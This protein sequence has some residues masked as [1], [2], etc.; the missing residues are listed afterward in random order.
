MEGSDDVASTAP[1]TMTETS[2]GHWNDDYNNVFVDRR[3]GYFVVSIRA[4]GNRSVQMSKHRS[5]DIAIK[6]AT[7]IANGDRAIFSDHSYDGPAK[8]AR[9]S[10]APCTELDGDLLCKMHADQWVRGERREELAA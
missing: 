10:Q 3:R 1:K 6:A 8:C 7:K 9:C 4:A 2:P 5:V